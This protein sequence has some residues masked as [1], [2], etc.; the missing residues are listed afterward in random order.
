MR[1]AEGAWDRATAQLDEVLDERFGRGKGLLIVCIENF[2][3]V[4]KEAFRRPEDQRRLRA[5]LDRPDGR[6]MLIAASS[7]GRFEGGTV[8]VPA[9]HRTDGLDTG[10]DGG[11]PGMRDARPDR[12]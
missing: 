3:V 12:A 5:W 4:I 9:Q 2:E 1:E 6:I 7:G 10:P 11:L 8:R